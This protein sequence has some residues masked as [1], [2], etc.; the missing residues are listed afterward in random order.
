[1]DEYNRNDQND[2]NENKTEDVSEKTIEQKADNEQNTAA[3]TPIYQSYQ[4]YNAENLNRSANGD[5][6]QNTYYYTQRPATSQPVY[7]QTNG[8][9]PKKQEDTFGVIS[10][11]CALSFVLFLLCCCCCLPLAG[12]FLALVFACEI[13][14][15]VLA[16]ISRRKMGRFTGM[17]ITGLVISIVILVV[18]ISVFAFAAV[19]YSLRPDYYNDLFR[20]MSEPGYYVEFFEEHEPDFYRENK[21]EVDEYFKDLFEILEGRTAN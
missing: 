7:G 17:A 9:P 1:M 3:S 10:V 18:M 21:E 8:Q 11:C 5:Q 2:Q 20:A 12:V 19:E 4:S 15:I 6:G 14:A 13:A 16:F